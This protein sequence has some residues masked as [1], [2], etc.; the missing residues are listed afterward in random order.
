MPLELVAANKHC[1]IE[2]KK[3][4]LRKCWLDI[5]EGNIVYCKKYG[6]EKLNGR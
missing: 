6:S 2:L 1:Y 5:L 4:Y 3:Q